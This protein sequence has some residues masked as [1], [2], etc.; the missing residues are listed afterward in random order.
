[1][2]SFTQQSPTLLR[3]SYICGVS[4]VPDSKQVES[5][6]VWTLS[7]LHHSPPVKAS[8]FGAVLDVGVGLDPGRCTWAE[9]FLAR[10]EGPFVTCTHSCYCCVC[11]AWTHLAA[12]GTVGVTSCCKIYLLFTFV[13]VLSLP[14]VQSVQTYTGSLF[15][16]KHFSSQ[17]GLD[18]RLALAQTSPRTAHKWKPHEDEPAKPGLWRSA[19]E[20]GLSSPLESIHPD[21]KFLPKLFLLLSAW[22]RMWR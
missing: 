17:T 1:M 7:W 14:R 12:S 10:Q 5:A 6:S 3:T 4:S 22:R 21:S 18:L 20:P 13:L 2:L 9:A 11:L 15:E 8:R 16:W 19:S